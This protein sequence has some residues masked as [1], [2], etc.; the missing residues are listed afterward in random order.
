MNTATPID[1]ARPSGTGVV[2]R[3]TTALS[4]HVSG[5]HTEEID[6]SL[7]LRDLLRI[8]LKRKWWIVSA[9]LLVL[10]LATFYTLLQ[11]PI[12]R[13]TTTIQIERNAARVVD[14]KDGT[15]SDQ[16]AYDEREFLATQYELL[17]SKA[18]AERVMESLRLDLDRK[19]PSRSKE[20][21]AGDE[22]LASDGLLDR[23]LATMRK[24][25]EPAVRDLNILDRE[26]VIGSLRGAVSIEPVRNARLV[27][28]NADGSDP[29][30]AAKIANTWA[31]SFI[32]SNLERRVDASSYAKTFL[33][34]QLAATKEKL[35]ESERQL[36]EYT[37]Q[38]QIVN[39]DDKT[40][41]VAQSLQEFNAALSRAEQDRIK[42]EATYSE[43]KRNLA[44]SREVLENKSVSSLRDSKAKLETDY[45]EQLKV[46][47]PGFPKM[48]QLQ[49]QID[50][51]DKKI[52]AEIA[53]V[54]NSIE[55]SAKAAFDAA[56]IQESQLRARADSAK[57]NVL[58]L[59]NQG[60]RYNILKRDVDT[61]REI[62]NGL[63][64]RFKEVGVAAGVGTNNI[65]VV[66][67]A[68]TPLFPF[69]PDVLRN[70]MIG[71]A[72]GLMIGLGLAFLLEHL[73]DSI[74]F[75]DEVE[76]F[77]GLTLVGVVPKASTRSGMAITSQVAEDPRSAL[78][79]AYRS[80]R[81]AL[82]FS[83]SRGA[84]R[85]LAVT[86]CAKGE[87]KST[88]AFSI[89]LA[90]SQL[91]KK[92]LLVDADMRNP[93]L[94]KVLGQDHSEGLSNLL[95]SSLDPLKI[96]RLTAHSGLYFISAGPLPPNPAELLSGDN[97]SKLLA[98]GSSTFDHIVVDAPPVLG[99]ADA[100]VLCK[101]VD[102]CLFVI[103]C[104]R[105]RK[106]S[107]R[108]A[109]KRL[110]QTGTHPLGAILTK[111]PSSS[112]LYG[113]DSNYYYYGDNPNAPKLGKV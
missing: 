67:K 84:P 9:S 61:N 95:S 83:T 76:R 30:L 77:T 33:Q 63:L 37:R 86:S 74:K 20:N 17:K 36:N 5:T 108:N 68:D 50:E 40:N 73:D 85:T 4:T 6:D 52:K 54:S 94:H 48:Q 7:H 113:Y 38:K 58:E 27:K 22:V 70:A 25:R 71:L 13:A 18:L 89:A 104:G 62:Y 100:V 19:R 32:A 88:S 69:K 26:S 28:I 111:L 12:Y 14:F 78:A 72:L 24:R 56:R 96:T 97:L 105:T 16:F 98:P 93:A 51:L 46:F 3:Q 44:N 45:Q 8:I 79:E 49:S 53:L 10:V 87:G 112:S 103:E 60:I 1:P 90:L 110:H 80:L 92:V 31:E 11:T 41:L 2:V 107:I 64:Q 101:Q 42:A 81:T 43:T 91:G 109:L 102:A 59:Q 34:Q 23:I 35:E 29:A 21:P 55:T 15:N 75:P 82:Q 39:V 106:T 99:I 47:K 65:S 57:R 66:D